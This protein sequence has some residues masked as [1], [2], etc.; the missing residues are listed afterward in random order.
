MSDGLSIDIIGL[1]FGVH[2]LLVMIQ[3]KIAGYHVT[4]CDGQQEVRDSGVAEQLETD[5]QRGDGA[6][7]HAAENGCHAYC[8]A[9]SRRETKY[10]AEQAPKSGPGEESGDDLAALKAGAECG[11]GKKNLEKKS[12]GANRGFL[13]TA[14][15]KV[16]TGAVVS[17]ISHQQGEDDDDT[18]ACKHADIRVFDQFFIQMLRAVEGDAEQYADQSTQNGQDRYFD[19]GHH[20]KIGYFRYDEG[21]RCDS[22][23]RGNGLSHQSGNNAGNQSCVMHD[24]HAD[25]FHGKDRSGYRSAKQGRKSGAHAAHDHNILILG[26]QP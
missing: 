4:E 19:G 3:A 16:H 11:G 21:L 6:V 25:D 12:F 17:L 7:G 1:V 20:G 22:R 8:G 26:I 9:E 2:D 10:A 18:A 15:N 13:H 14:P 23:K 5:Q 24:S